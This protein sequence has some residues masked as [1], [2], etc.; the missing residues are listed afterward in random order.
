MRVTQQ[1][2]TTHAQALVVGYQRTWCGDL[3]KGTGLGYCKDSN[4]FRVIF[5]LSDYCLT[6]RGLGFIRAAA[7]TKADNSDIVHGAT[8]PPKVFVFSTTRTL[9]TGMNEALSVSWSALTTVS[10]SAQY[11]RCFSL[12]VLT[13]IRVVKLTQHNTNIK[14]MF[15]TLKQPLSPVTLPSLFI[16][17]HISSCYLT[18]LLC[19]KCIQ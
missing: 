5:G 15:R 2:I 19:L 6:Q 13:R 17:L 18:V 14:F 7:A 9:H 16:L 1:D 8:K 11:R 12:R 4:E 3:Q 10:N